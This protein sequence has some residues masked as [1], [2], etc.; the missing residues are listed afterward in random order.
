M[1]RV[2]GLKAVDQTAPAHG[3]LSLIFFL[4]AKEV[5]LEKKMISSKFMP[6][7]RETFSRNYFPINLLDP[8][9]AIVM[10]GLVTS[11]S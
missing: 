6:F 7:I 4:L 1:T 11:G 2:K 9:A 8:A 3:M 10:D 5:L